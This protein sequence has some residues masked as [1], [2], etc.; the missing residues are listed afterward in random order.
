[1]LGNNI[2]KMEHLCQIC[3]DYKK[4]MQLKEMALAQLVTM[5]AQSNL[6]YPDTISDEDIFESMATSY[7]KR[8]TGYL[9]ED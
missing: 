9:K 3:E 8:A 1:M 6:A 2:G 4:S 5:Y 7:M